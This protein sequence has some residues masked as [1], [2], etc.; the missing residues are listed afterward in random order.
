ME[1]VARLRRTIDGG[2]WLIQVGINKII[3]CT[4]SALKPKKQA[5]I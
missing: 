4:E 3:Q 2:S 5:N 1:A